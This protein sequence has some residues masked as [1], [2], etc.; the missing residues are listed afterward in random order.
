LFQVS[1]PFV[2]EFHG[3]KPG[4]NFQSFRF[5]TTYSYRRALP[6]S[7]GS[8]YNHGTI[9]KA[10]HFSDKAGILWSERESSPFAYKSDNCPSQPTSIATSQFATNSDAGS[11][12]FAFGFL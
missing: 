4:Y 7:L 11:F 10:K 1:K 5:A 8:C 2:M 9:T 3:T 6:R 12:C